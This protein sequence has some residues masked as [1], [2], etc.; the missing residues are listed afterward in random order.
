MRDFLIIPYLADTFYLLRKIPHVRIY[1]TCTSKSIDKQ[2]TGFYG[3]EKE[4][5]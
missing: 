4:T 3:F 2:V 1:I 5:K